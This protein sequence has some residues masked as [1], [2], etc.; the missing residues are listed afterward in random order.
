MIR[1]VNVAPSQ[2]FGDNPTRDFPANHWIIRAFG[3][4]QPDGHT[5]EDYPCTAGTPVRSVTSGTVLHVGWFGGT[6]ADNPWWIA[7]SFAGYCYVVDHGAFI[8]IYGHCLDDGAH[9]GVGQRV[10]EGQTLGL[11]GNTG[12]STGD[13][14]H[15]E[16]LPNGYVL[17]SSM[18]GRINPAPLFTGSLSYAGTIT[19]IEED[20]L[21]FTFEDLKRAAT[22][23]ALAALDYKVDNTVGGKT[24]VLDVPRII[25]ERFNQVPGA[26]L[27]EQTPRAGE[28]G[29]NTSLRGVLAYAD[30]KHIEALRA[31]VTAAHG[32]GVS[33]DQIIE[34]VREALSGATITLGGK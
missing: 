12:A 14:L 7:P 19:P 34:A 27:D 17:N 9:V 1:P 32:D 2:M 10:D 4:Y 8:G 18:Y 22:E 26:V 6:Y 21:P 11:S 5:G 20:E 13:H 28:F 33:A 23:G 29:G 16:V 31:S 15:F 30:Q 24:S 3:N 25:D